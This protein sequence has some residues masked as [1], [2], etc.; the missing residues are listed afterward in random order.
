MWICIVDDVGS[1][2]SVIVKLYRFLEMLIVDDDYD[3]NLF[4]DFNW[5]N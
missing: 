1:C 4:G 3:D 5:M 2:P